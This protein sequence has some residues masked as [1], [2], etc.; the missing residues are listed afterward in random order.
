MKDSKCIKFVT[1]H[2]INAIYV[3]FVI[4]VI[5]YHYYGIYKSHMELKGKG[6][7]LTY[8]LVGEDSL[9]RIRRL[10]EAQ[11]PYSVDS[12]C[13]SARYLNV[14]HASIMINV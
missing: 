6:E 13:T 3:M 1:V 7:V 14:Y 9:Q 4:Y 2:H 5:L 12:A 11:G 8:W 10:A